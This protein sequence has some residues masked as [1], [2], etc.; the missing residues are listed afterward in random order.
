MRLPMDDAVKVIQQLLEGCS[1]R[2]TSRLTGIDKNTI[3]TLLVHVGS[4]CKRMMEA[5][6]TNICV[7]DVQ[8]DEIWSF[9]GC[10]EK[11]RQ[12][13]EYGEAY[14]DAYTFV[15]IERT[16]KLV[17]AWHLGKRTTQH[18]EQ[19]AEKLNRATSGKFQLTT[20]GFT[21]YKS[22]MPKEFGHR[23]DFMQLVKVYGK[24]GVEEQRRYS[25]PVVVGVDYEAIIG[26]PIQDRACTSHIERSNLS[27]RMACRRFTRLTNGFSKKW[28]NHRSALAL[29]FAFYNFARVHMTLK[30]E[31]PAMASGIE[32]HVWTIR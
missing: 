19:F 16:T 23:V 8:A 28:D 11:T 2:S 18:T 9:I 27:L 22:V 30:T 20:D 7:D 10:K 32:N 24:T 4:N 3:M 25:P 26:E 29:W 6:I 12:A 13:K 5:K 15:G 1:V 21:P 14:G 17:V 31:T